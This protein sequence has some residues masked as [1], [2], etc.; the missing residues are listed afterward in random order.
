MIPIETIDEPC[1]PARAGAILLDKFRTGMADLMKGGYSA[2]K[3]E[4]AE[5]G[6]D[7]DNAGEARTTE[8]RMHES[9]RQFLKQRN[10]FET[11]N[12]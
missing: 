5:D 8:G 4:F 10:V 11:S 3:I 6:Y 12:K 2:V 9:K 1:Y 7:S